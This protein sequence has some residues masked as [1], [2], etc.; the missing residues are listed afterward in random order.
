MN[1]DKMIQ[2][3]EALESGEYEQIRGTWGQLTIGEDDILDNGLSGRFCCLNVASMVH[4]GMDIGEYCIM[5][6]LTKSGEFDHDM[7]GAAVGHILEW[8]EEKTP[9]LNRSF[10]CWNDMDQFT[11]P[12]IAAEIRRMIDEQQ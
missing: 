7:A 4:T 1:K 2:W 5:K 11:F 10:V 12:Q 6:G 8:S 3:A 9:G